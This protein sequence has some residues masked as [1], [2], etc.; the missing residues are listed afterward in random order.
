MYVCGYVCV[1]MYI[2]IYIYIYTDKFI[3]CVGVAFLLL[4]GP[5]YLLWFASTVWEILTDI[6]PDHAGLCELILSRCPR[7]AEPVDKLVAD[8]SATRPKA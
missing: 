7:R 8:S 4:I 2:H 3:N 5:W 1:Y 6:F